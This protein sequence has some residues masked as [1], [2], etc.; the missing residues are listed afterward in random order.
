M[1]VFELEDTSLAKLTIYSE[2]RQLFCL[3]L[4]ELVVVYFN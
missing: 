4:V 1:I 3:Q 2:A